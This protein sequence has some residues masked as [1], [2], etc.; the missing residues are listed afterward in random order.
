MCAA[1]FARLAAVDYVGSVAGGPA[2]GGGFRLAVSY[3]FLTATPP[4][5]AAGRVASSAL[6]GRHF[7]ACASPGSVNLESAARSECTSTFR[8]GLDAY[9]VGRW[10]RCTLHKATWVD[11]A[12]PCRT[13][14]CSTKLGQERVRATGGGRPTA[15][16][17]PL[18]GGER[19]KIG[20]YASAATKAT[21]GGTARLTG[22]PPRRT[23]RKGAFG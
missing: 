22:V 18:P 21:P 19:A 3:T 6:P 4:R 14:W 7:D 20:A 5:R 12:D 2:A 17:G 10:R 11:S 15:E 8:Q 23:A 16:G 1:R 13:A 9:S